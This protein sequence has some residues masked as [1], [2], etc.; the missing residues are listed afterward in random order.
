MKCKSS[1]PL[2]VKGK[3]QFIRVLQTFSA[4]KTVKLAAAIHSDDEMLRQV[5]GEDLI[6]KEF[7]MHLNCYKECTRVCSKQSLGGVNSL[8]V[9]EGS[10]NETRTANN[11]KTVCSFIMDYVIGGHQS[12][13]I[14]VLTEMYGFDKEDSRLRSKVKQRIENEFGHKIASVSIGY[15]EPQIVVS[16][17]VLEDTGVCNFIKENKNFILKESA[18]HFRSDI[19]EMISKAS[20]LPWPKL[21]HGLTDSLLKVSKNFLDLCFIQHIIHLEMMSVSMLSHFP[22]ILF[23]LY[24][25]VTS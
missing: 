9:D 22:K 6:A 21:F 12:V 11:F 20:E 23:M 18:R 14:K 4:C 16:R 2:K 24:R 1:L 25:E 7:K 5:T 13:S 15:H 8:S 17:S 10:E 19:T 3:K